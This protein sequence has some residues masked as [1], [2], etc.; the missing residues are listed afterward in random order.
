MLQKK[1][2]LQN[3][4]FLG[5]RNKKLV[6]QHQIAK[7]IPVWHNHLGICSGI[8]DASAPYNAMQR[9]ELYRPKK[10]YLFFTSVRLYRF[11]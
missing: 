3:I 9:V 7:Q 2:L 5:Y 1:S 11:K 8:T 4:R 6:S 10:T